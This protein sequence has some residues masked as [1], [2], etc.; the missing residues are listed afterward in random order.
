MAVSYKKL[1]FKL[2]ELDM[3]K[4]DL[5]RAAEISTT[6]LTKLNKSEPVSM[7][8]IMKICKALKCDVGDVMEVINKEDKWTS[9]MI[10]S[11]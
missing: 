1:W 11:V 7:D 3:T 8:I 6:T 2:V 9:R 5:R 4:A 10:Q